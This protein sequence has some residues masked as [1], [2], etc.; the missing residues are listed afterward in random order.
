MALLATPSIEVHFEQRCHKIKLSS[1]DGEGLTYTR[2]LYETRAIFSLWEKQQILFSTG[3]QNNAPVL[4][5]T[6]PLE[7]FAGRS[8]FVKVM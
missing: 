2:L 6:E 1:G 4:L 8:L 3:P 5:S 7:N